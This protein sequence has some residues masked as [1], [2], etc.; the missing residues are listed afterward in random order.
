MSGPGGDAPVGTAMAADQ[1]AALQP[2]ALLV[3]DPSPSARRAAAPTLAEQFEPRR[4]GLNAVR[5]G[6]AVAV[7]VWH[8]APLTGT[9]VPWAPVRQ[10]GGSLWV[11]AFF[12]ISG[13]LITRSW[14]RNPRLGSYLRARVLRILPAFYVCLAVTAFVIAPLAVRAQGQTIAVAD[15]LHYVLVNSLLRVQEY[16]IAGTPTDVPFPGVWNGSIWTLWWEAL[17]YLGIAAVGLVGLL[18]RSRATIVALFALFWCA[19]LAVTLDLVER[20]E[21]RMAARFGLMFTAGALLLVLADRIRVRWRY[22]MWA[23][24]LLVPA[25]FLADYRLVAAPLVAYCAIGVGSMMTA[26]R[27]RFTQDISYGTYVYAFPLQQLLAC[28]GLAVLPMALFAGL[29]IVVTLPVAAA[30]WFLVERPALRLK[31]RRRPSGDKTA[32]SASSG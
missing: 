4:N 13:F 5:L 3:D 9:D 29:A 7:I 14:L 24:L 25:A 20:Y 30:S 26:P 11:D 1:D 17:C 19:E 2:E 8:S 31:G 12:A 22:V 16:G 28:V 6:L 23:A 18:R 21:F 15:S 10:V 32:L 27:W